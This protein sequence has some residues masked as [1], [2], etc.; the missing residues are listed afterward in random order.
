MGV[1]LFV[2]NERQSRLKILNCRKWQHNHVT[3]MKL[4][5]LSLETEAEEDLLTWSSSA[6]IR[7]E[8][9]E[10]TDDWQ[11]TQKKIGGR[12][13]TWSKLFRKR[14]ISLEEFSS[15]NNGREEMWL[16]VRFVIFTISHLKSQTLHCHITH[17]ESVADISGWCIQYCLLAQLHQNVKPLEREMTTFRDKIREN[18]LAAAAAIVWSASLWTPT[19]SYVVTPTKPPSR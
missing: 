1:N 4:W 7:I 10:W 3:W 13:T 5:P 2:V 16:G 6:R 17:I 14:K 11:E 9:W 19:L 8:L 12:R 15:R 18:W